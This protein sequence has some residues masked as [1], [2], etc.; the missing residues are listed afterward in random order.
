MLKPLFRFGQL[1]DLPSHLSHNNMQLK[2][3]L[4]I[5][6]DLSLHLARP[7][8]ATSI[9]AAVDSQRNYLSEWLP[10]VSSTKRLKDTEN[11]IKESMQ[12][13]TNGTRLTTFILFQEE[14]AGSISVVN[15]NKDNKSCE[16]GYWL[17]EKLQGKGIMTQTCKAFIDHLFK[18]KSL[19][20]IEIKVAVGNAK[21]LSIPLRLGF[22]KEGVLRQGLLLY[23]RYLDL[24][25]FSLLK[26]EWEA[27]F[28]QKRD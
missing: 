11:F 9:F 14:L 5:N 3:Y 26:C 15:F 22:T 8:L 25:L 19:N 20:R 18:T 24:S 4:K 1:F 23:G 28:Q 27:P 6:S 2:P 17:S 10:W 21:S 7:E 16:I 12:H 13:N